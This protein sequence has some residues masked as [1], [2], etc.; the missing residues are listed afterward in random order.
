MFEFDLS[1]LIINFLKLD[2]TLSLIVS[3][4]Q[5]NMMNYKYVE[6]QRQILPLLAVNKMCS[7][8]VSIVQILKMWH[9]HTFF[10]VSIL[11]MVLTFSCV[12]MAIISWNTLVNTEDGEW[13]E[14]GRWQALWNLPSLWVSGVPGLPSRQDGKVT[15]AG[16]KEGL[17]K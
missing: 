5:H 6:F 8:T 1:Y 10:Y 9:K 15:S 7:Y 11:C 2:F 16:A 3:S 13:H 12:W 17:Y 14:T 4:W